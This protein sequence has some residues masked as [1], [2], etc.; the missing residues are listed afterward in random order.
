MQTEITLPGPLLNDEGFLAQKGWARNLILEYDRNRVKAGTLRI[1]EWDYYCILHPEYGIAITVADNAYMGFYALTFFDFINRT[2]TTGYV[3]E[4]FSM[5]KLNMPGSSADGDVILDHKKFQASFQHADGKRKISFNFPA[6]YK[7]T[8]IRGEIDLNP[9]NKESMV[10]ATPFKEN[11]HSFYYNQKINCLQASGKFT[12]G[13][14]EYVFSPE[15]SYG[16]LDWGRGVWTYNNH[17]YWGSASGVVE[18]KPFGFNIG[19]GFGDTSAAS[20]NMLFYKGIAHK[21]DQ[22]TFHINT[23]NYLEPW[24]FSSNDGRF[25]LDFFPV[26]DRF[27]NTNLLILKS[28]Q[29][30]VFGYFTGNVVLDDGTFLT[31]NKLLG[32]AEDVINRW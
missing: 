29:H 28:K 21:L 18:G 31:I 26:I 4:P 7:E 9:M 13:D 23:K 15:N 32:F 2:E 10:I 16:V 3:I 6:F 14:K 30:Q 1:K 8:A 11:P 24:K 17:W 19:Y 12:F 20:E 22:V 27:S 25:E 5:G